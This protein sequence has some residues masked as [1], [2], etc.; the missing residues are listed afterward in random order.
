MAGKLPALWKAHVDGDAQLFYVVVVEGPAQLDAS[1]LVRV[2]RASPE[3]V[4]RALAHP[5]LDAYDLGAK[6]GHD[7]GGA[8]AGQLARKVAN[9]YVGQG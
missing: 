6:Y 8:G 9:S 3:H 7:A 4:P 1:A 5:V 2:G